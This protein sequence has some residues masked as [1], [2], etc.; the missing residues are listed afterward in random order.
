M[1][2]ITLTRET[3][4]EQV[5]DLA[6][7]KWYEEQIL[8]DEWE[9]IDNPETPAEYVGKLYQWLLDKDI[10]DTLV[11]IEKDRIEQE[12]KDSVWTTDLLIE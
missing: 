6:K 2:K 10:T 5:L 12:I 3:T 9:F 8:N 4:D 7:A 11:K 1:P